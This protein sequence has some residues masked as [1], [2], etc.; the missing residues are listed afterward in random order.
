MRL[1][2]STSLINKH[3]PRGT[4]PLTELEAVVS[5]AVD[6]AAGSVRSQRDYALEW[7]RSREWVKARIDEFSAFGLE[8]EVAL[9]RRRKPRRP[10]PAAIDP[11]TVEALRLWVARHNN[12][13]IQALAGQLELHLEAALAWH[14]KNDTTARDWPATWRNWLA[15]EARLQAGRP[16]NPPRKPKPSWDDVGRSIA[17]EPA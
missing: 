7:K 15:K 3:H 2:L 9:P 10:V 11:E 16:M 1:D 6:E 5:L 17:K 14:T 8:G 4:R 12:P 13:E